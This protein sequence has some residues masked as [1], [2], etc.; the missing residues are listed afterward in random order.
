LSYLERAAA[1]RPEGLLVLHHGRGTDESD[2][3]G[4]AEALDPER[5]L[6]VVTPRAPLQLPGSPGYHWYLVPRVGYPDRDS[7]QA[8][9][10][11]LA[12]LHDTL[13]EETGIDP[14]RTVLGGFSMGAAMSYA[15]ALGAD[16]PAV[17]GVL[18]FSGFVPVVEGWEPH[19]DDR[20]RT[21]AF[22]AHGRRDPIVEIGFARRAR[23]L[24]AEGG[25]EVEYHESDLGHQIDPVHLSAASEWLA[26]ATTAAPPGS[27]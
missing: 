12:V 1:D 5:R 22:V 21:R 18:A 13:W 23:E 17:A 7:F 24:L 14:S 10:G 4:L 15:M 8:A 6:R 3:L 16:R 27:S 19:F 20:R 2:L 11:A 26:A 9:R 25:V